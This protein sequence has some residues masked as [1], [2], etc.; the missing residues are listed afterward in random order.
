MRKLLIRT[1]SGWL[2]RLVRPEVWLLTACD[3]R[4]SS[5]RI[6]HDF[7]SAAGLKH[8]NEMGKLATSISKLLSGSPTKL[9]R[10]KRPVF[11]QRP[12][13]G[14]PPERVDA[15]QQLF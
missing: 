3:K 11:T 8:G 12:S 10:W 14:S 5:S 9:V 6:D 2:E 7:I 1:A 4:L 13:A 15:K